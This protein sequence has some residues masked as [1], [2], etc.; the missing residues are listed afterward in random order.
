MAIDRLIAMMTMSPTTHIS[1]YNYVPLGS[2][3]LTSDEKVFRV[4]STDC[5]DNNF[6]YRT[7]LS[8]RFKVKGKFEFLKS[9]SRFKAHLHK[10]FYARRRSKCH[11]PS[12]EYVNQYF[13]PII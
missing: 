10:K 5:R 6:M 4:L 9:L 13:G 1:M 2:T 8:F 12:Q 3:P 7:W 11:C